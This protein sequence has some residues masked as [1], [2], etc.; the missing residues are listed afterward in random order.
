MSL[1]M[2]SLFISHGGGPWPWVPDMDAAFHK[3]R[4]WLTALPKTLPGKP[5]AILSFS[6]HWEA[7][8]FTA[9]TAEKPSMIYDYS[10]F[11]AHT[12]KIEYKAPGEPALARRVKELWHMMGLPS[13][14]DPYH[15]FDHGTFVPLSLMYP[16]GSVPIV[17]LSLLENYDPK[18]HII[19]GKAL[20]SLRREGV[21]I[22]GSG[23]SYHNMRGF[24]APH[25]KGVS[26]LFGRW[27]KETV[28]ESDIEE[29]ERRLIDWE[30][31]PAARHAHPAEDHLLPL[32]VVA[33]AAGNAIGRE[34]FLDHVFG[35]DMASYQ[36]G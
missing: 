24:G 28:E 6:G 16:D 25:A 4:E 21:L 12:Y 22:I 36:F 29:R 15:G 34:I 18:T 2:P 26:Q 8:S 1:T 5:S 32:H 30:K 23:L 11:P 31:A 27:L 17:S 19:A 13:A 9:S 10:G 3:T 35:V 20:E 14:E 33:G 7:P